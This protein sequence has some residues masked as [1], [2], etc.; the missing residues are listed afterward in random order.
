MEF[1]IYGIIF[2]MGTVFGSFFTLA[3]YRIPL[4]LDIFI[5]SSF[6]PNCQNQLKGR[7]LIPVLSYVFLGGK[8]RYCGK[9]IGPRYIILELLSGVVFLLFAISLKAD[10]FHLDMKV[11]MHFTFFVLYFVCL[12]IISGIEKEKGTIQK[13]VLLFG[14]I[15]A[16][17]YM[18]YACIIDGAV[19]YTYI[20]TLIRNYIFAYYRYSI[21]GKEI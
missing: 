8:C 3:T 2:I 9:K 17:A 20:I 10:I 21:S 12:F 18:I 13:S 6:C 11:I 14:I 1:I 19:I 5:K 15:S 4:G 7:D 16:L